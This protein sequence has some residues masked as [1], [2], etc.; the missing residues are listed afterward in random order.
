M[1]KN[2]ISRI[3]NLNKYS[4]ILCML[5]VLIHDHI[6]HYYD[7]GSNHLNNV[8]HYVMMDIIPKI[9]SIAVPSFFFLSGFLFFRNYKLSL[10]HI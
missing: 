8:L 1:E 7:Y 9:T 5:V 3:E 10:I 6:P 4:I 2:K